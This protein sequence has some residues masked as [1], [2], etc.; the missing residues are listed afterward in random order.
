MVALWH[1]KRLFNFP[2][3]RGFSPELI[4]NM[5]VTLDHK[6]QQIK[7]FGIDRIRIQRYPK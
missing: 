4:F 2:L 6:T 5:T 7:I 3:I 1:Y